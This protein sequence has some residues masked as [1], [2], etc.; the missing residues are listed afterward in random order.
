MNFE[1]HIWDGTM[2]KKNNSSLLNNIEEKTDFYFDI[3]T[4]TELICLATTPYFLIFAQLCKTIIYSVV[5][6]I[7]KK[8]NVRILNK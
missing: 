3:V 5:N 7:L 1:F 2:L 6:F 8:S 4:M